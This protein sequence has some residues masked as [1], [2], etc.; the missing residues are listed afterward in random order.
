MI[1]RATNKILQLRNSNFKNLT[2]TMYSMKWVWQLCQK[3]QSNY[4]EMEKSC[5]SMTISHKMIPFWT[6]SIFPLKNVFYKKSVLKNFAIATGKDLWR[7]IFLTTAKPL[8]LNNVFIYYG[9]FICNEW[10]DKIPKCRTCCSCIFI[11]I[12]EVISFHFSD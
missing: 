3:T 10:L 8:P 11:N 1:D 6:K 12:L 7:S 2:N 5:P 9:A 4:L